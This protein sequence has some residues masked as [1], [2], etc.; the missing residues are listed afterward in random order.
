MAQGA[1]PAVLHIVIASVSQRQLIR[2][3]TLNIPHNSDT[4]FLQT[5]YSDLSDYVFCFETDHLFFCD[6]F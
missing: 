6:L 4:A 3:S 5:Q 2:E 1:S